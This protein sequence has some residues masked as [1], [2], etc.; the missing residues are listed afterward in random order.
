MTPFSVRQEYI[1][2]F[3]RNNFAGVGYTAHAF[4]DKWRNG[5]HGNFCNGFKFFTKSLR[6]HFDNCLT[7]LVGSFQC[8]RDKLFLIRSDIE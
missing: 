1:R 5:T 2:N 7:Y 4:N 3:R 8:K 6:P